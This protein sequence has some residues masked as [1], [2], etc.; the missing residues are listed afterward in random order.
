[1]LA[2]GCLGEFSQDRCSGLAHLHA[3]EDTAL[4]IQVLL[5]TTHADHTPGARGSDADFVVPIRLL[6]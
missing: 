3:S 4:T 5:P 2:Q 6:L 1:M